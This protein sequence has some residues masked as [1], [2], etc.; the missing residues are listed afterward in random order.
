MSKTLFVCVLAVVASSAF[1]LSCTNPQIESTSF[2]TQDATIVSHIAFISEFSLKCSNPEALNL[3]LFAE[4]NGR[5]SPV[6]R[7]S[8]D[9]FQV[10]LCL[11]YK[12]WIVFKYSIKTQSNSLPKTISI[13]INIYKMPLIICR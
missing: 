13:S 3:P 2:T 11:L 6:V 9:K 5:L 4:V 10:S 8:A 12:N 7:L 1:G